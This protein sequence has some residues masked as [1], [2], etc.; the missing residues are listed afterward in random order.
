MG[1]DELIRRVR[2]VDPAQGM[3]PLSPA[4]REEL[5]ESIVAAPV[6]HASRVGSRPRRRLILL[7][8][9]GLLAAV[10]AAGAGAWALGNRASD[11]STL[12]CALEPD[13][14]TGISSATGDP[15]A[16]CA[17]EWRRLFRTAPPKLI[18]YDT[19]GAVTV[20]PAGTPVPDDWKPLSPTFRQN[21]D[22]IELDERL[23][24]SVRGLDSRCHSLQQARTLAQTL[25]ATLELEGWSVV[26]DPRSRAGSDSCTGYSLDAAN[27]HVVLISHDALQP[28]PSNAPHLVL[29][30]RLGELTAATCLTAEATAGIVRR[31][32]AKFGWQESDSSLIVNSIPGNDCADV[33]VN[34]GGRVEVTIRGGS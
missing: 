30:R 31:E 24:D 27:R 12:M 21:A 3:E 9:V 1:A 19:R 17:A 4:A 23:G 2:D 22:L 10:A 5:R 26:T 32:A 14:G 16:D 7:L 11:T 25:L 29:A 34:V 28:R 8:G 33:V 15:I 20:V 13:V 6:P 18:A